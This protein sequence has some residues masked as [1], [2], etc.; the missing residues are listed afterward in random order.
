MQELAAEYS[1]KV[2]EEQVLKIFVAAKIPF[3]VVE[4]VEFRNL[5]QLL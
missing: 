3:S 1:H 5:I 4:H 2:L